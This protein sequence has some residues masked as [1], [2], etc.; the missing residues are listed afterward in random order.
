MKKFVFL[1]LTVLIFSQ[2]GKDDEPTTGDVKLSFRATF[3]N[4]PLVFNTIY[5]YLPERFIQ[6]SKFDMFISNITLTGGPKGD[7]TLVDITHLDFDLVS[8][9]AN[10]A[11]A[12]LYLDLKKV[13]VGNYTGISMGI[14]VRPDI[15][16]TK[17]TNYTSDNPL[18][19]PELYWAG[20]NS[21]IFSRMEGKLDSVS[22]GLY[23][24][25]MSYHTGLNDYYRVVNLS[26]P[27]KVAGGNSNDI[28]V[29]INI[30]EIFKSGDTYLDILKITE[31]HGPSD[32]KTIEKIV[33]NYSHA[34]TVSQ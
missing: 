2:C 13:P 20:W 25:G 11:K 9:D 27:L 23:A 4:N 17:P 30:K 8:K 31:A 29:N 15:N 16:A 19:N 1:L 12:G 7:T 26:A 10:S 24:T 22:T 33:D 28:N 21:Y 3:E 5:Q 32:R 6:F 34:I 14:G 18:S